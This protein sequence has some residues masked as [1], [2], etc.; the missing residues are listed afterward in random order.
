[1]ND[2]RRSDSYYDEFDKRLLALAPLA[3]SVLPP[4]T[5]K[6]YLEYVQ[7][8]EY[9]LAV[10]VAA[11]VISDNSEGGRDLAKELMLAAEKMGLGKAAVELRV[12]A[13]L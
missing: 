1:V 13:G 6:W 12:I 11:E 4:D 10:E 5:M 9:G 8:G 2:G 7:A 3:R